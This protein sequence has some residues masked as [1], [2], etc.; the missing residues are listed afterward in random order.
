MDIQVVIPY[1]SFPWSLHDCVASMGKSDI[2]IL[3]VD[4]SPNSGTKNLNQGNQLDEYKNIEYVY[5]PKNY[6][7]AGSWNMGI[8]K[9]AAYTLIVSTSVRFGKSLNEVAELIPERA[10]KTMCIYEGYHMFAISKRLVD[11]VGTFDENF[12]PAYGEDQEFGHRLDLVGIYPQSYYDMGNTTIGSG[13][14]KRSGLW[15]WDRINTGRMDDYYV[16]KWGSHPGH[17]KTPFNNP[18]NPLSYWPKVHH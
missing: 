18:D 7:V 15:D 17:F 8:A 6:G 9:G 3:V 14:Q 12:Y 10:G 4:N 1:L 5:Y 11:K 13:I 16:H 2:P